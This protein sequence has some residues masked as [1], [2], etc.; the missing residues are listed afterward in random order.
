MLP[1][2]NFTQTQAYQY[3]TDHFIEINNLHLRGLF[4]DDTE[5]FNKFS[6]EWNDIL[7]DYS[8]NRITDKTI[9]LLVQLA[10]ECGLKDAIDA[11]FGAE[12]INETESRAVLHIA[13]RNQG[14]ERIVVDGVDVMPD[15]KAVL[16][17][18][19]MFAIL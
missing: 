3:L 17:K 6:L 1:K 14:N 13:L 4:A 19:E 8:K 10:K 16:D 15:V 2:I 18:M 12:Q 11:M 5:R 9:A 7:L